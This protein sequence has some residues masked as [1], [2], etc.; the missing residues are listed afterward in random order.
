MADPFTVLLKDH[1][2]VEDRL[3]Q[4]PVASRGSVGVTSLDPSHDR[5]LDG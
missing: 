3:G 5:G 1:R 2:E 4:K